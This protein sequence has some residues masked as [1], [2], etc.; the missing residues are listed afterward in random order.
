MTLDDLTVAFSHIDRNSLLSDWDWLLQG[1]FLPILIS[2]SGDA[3]V[4]HVNN[5]QV[6]WLDTG[7]GELIQV[8]DSVD[9]FK[10][11]LSNKEFVAEKFAVQMI[12]D[13]IQSGKSL[14]HG[15]IYSLS[16]PWLLGGEYEI[17]NIEPTDLEVH[18]SLLGQIAFQVAVAKS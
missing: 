15:Q 18:F 5:G 3:F 16:K 1:A 13:L 2:A 11:K 4:Q 9:E 7:G 6:W 10:V 17:S 12:G 14:S 8:S